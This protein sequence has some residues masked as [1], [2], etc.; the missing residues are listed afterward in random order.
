MD[1]SSRIAA[2]CGL[3]AP[4]YLLLADSSDTMTG[5][6]WWAIAI[7]VPMALFGLGAWIIAARRAAA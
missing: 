5:V 4:T 1:T 7:G 2:A 6:W 3:R